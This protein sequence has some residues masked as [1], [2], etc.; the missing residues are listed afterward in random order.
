MGRSRVIP[1]YSPHEVSFV[2]G[3]GVYLYD[4]DGKR[5]LDMGAG[6]ATSSLGH[7]NPSMIEALVK[8]AHEGPWHVSN[9]YTIPEAECL[10]KKLT[11]F[12]FADMA[13]FANSGAEAVECGLKIARSYQSG[14]GRHERYKVLTLRRSF[15]GRTYA[16]CSANEPAGFL[17]ALYPYVDWFASVN[18]DIQSVRDEV[19]KGNVGTILLEPVQGEGGIHVLSFDFLRELRTLCD[20]QDIL[21][22]FDCV[23][24]GS[25]R[26]GKFFAHEYSGITPDICSLAKGFGGGFPVG[27]CLINER[28]GQFVSQRMHGS[29]YG[30]NPLA[31]TVACAVVT[32]ILSP[33]FLERV[34]KNGNYLMEKLSDMSGR[35]PDIITDVRGMGLM[36][37]LQISDVISAPDLS[38]K[39]IEFGI[40]A[41]GTVNV[42]SNVLRLTP[43]LIISREEIDEFLHMFEAFLRKQEACL[44]RVH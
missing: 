16:T 35:F 22:F 4:K 38:K 23:Q 30:G 11:D 3:N 12:S 26:T 10:A 6:I 19:S 42:S 20:E 29:T 41:I 1:F 13:F 33:G 40:L 2:R 9:L 36:I 37:G 24:C 43:P 18:P 17:A 31:T 39:L 7:C 34:E 21:L 25:G 5:Y 28:A 32:E 15:H 14:I 27:A 8:K 44:S